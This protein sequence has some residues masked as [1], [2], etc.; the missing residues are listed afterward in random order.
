MKLC[1]PVRAIKEDHGE[2]WIL[3]MRKLQTL[4]DETEG[5]HQI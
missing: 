2:N 4:M 5:P 1:Q 3:E